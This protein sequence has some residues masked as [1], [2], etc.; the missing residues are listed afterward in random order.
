MIISGGVNIYPAEIE[1]CLVMHQSVADIAV[2]GVPDPEMGESVQAVV[3]PADGVAGTQEFAEEL[4]TFAREHLAGYK[5]PRFI[6]FRDE[7]PRLPT[8]KLAK[9]LL[10]D[11]YREQ[12]SR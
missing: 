11:E 1:S 9:G 3:Q 4:R 5:V 10:R 2:F 8:G 6:D 12:V 7:L